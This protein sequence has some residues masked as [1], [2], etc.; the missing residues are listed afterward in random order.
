ML[1]RLRALFARDPRDLSPAD[2]VRR[3]DDGALIVDVREADEF[4]AGSLRGATHIPLGEI[5]S[6]GLALQQRKG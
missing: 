6:L 4:A 3:I 1:K 2:A 5:R